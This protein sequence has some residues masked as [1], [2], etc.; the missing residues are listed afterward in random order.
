MTMMIRRRRGDL[1]R[2]SPMREFEDLYDR[3]GQLI[4]ATMGEM[5]FPREGVETPW[6]PFADVSETEDCYLV[7]AELPGVSKD[8]IN[9]QLDDRE[10]IIT[11][12]VREEERERMH[13]RMRRTGRFEFRTLLPGEIETEGV[14]AKLRDGVLTVKV[15]KAQ[16][17]K[18]RQIEVSA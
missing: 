6:V 2:L 9:V 15:P 1:S 13:H 12:E 5:T 10:L 7:E 4:S 14:D 8:Q 11:G 16:V 17:T 18:P 3:L